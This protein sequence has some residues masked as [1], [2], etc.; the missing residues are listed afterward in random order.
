M[1]PF[2]PSVI[3]RCGTACTEPLSR[4]QALTA[5]SLQVYVVEPAES[6]VPR[7]TSPIDSSL[8]DRLAVKVVPSLFD[9]RIAFVQEAP[10]LTQALQQQL[11]SR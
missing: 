4:A 2:R 3:W 1:A 6:R 11:H 10:Q 8:M 5:S 9:G 7:K